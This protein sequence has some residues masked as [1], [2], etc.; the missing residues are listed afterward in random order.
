MKGLRPQILQITVRNKSISIQKEDKMA[1]KYY[2]KIIPVYFF[3]AFL[4]VAP[5]YIHAENFINNDNYS[6]GT[7]DVLDIIVWDN[8][9]MGR[10]VEVSSKGTFTFPLIGKVHAKGLSIFELEN[11]ITERLADGYINDPQVSISVK[12]YDSQKVFLFGEVARPGSYVLK[13]KTHI[14]ELISKAGGFTDKSGRI[15][16]IVRPSRKSD[17]ESDIIEMNLGMFPDGGVSNDFY[18][19]N[20]DSIYIDKEQRIFIIGNVLKKGEFKWEKGLTIRTAIS[21]AGGPK[22]SAALK[23][24]KIIRIVGG[25]EVKIDTRMDDLVK[26]DDI[27]EV[28]ERY[29]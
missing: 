11:Y 4:N 22:E 20:G 29:F 12:K 8:N 16:K 3:I 25:K 19:I 10:S 13:R 15:I 18:V 24:T 27:I 26:P 5:L 7:D 1:N 9:D 21:L 6:I 2:L 23:R 14:L 28:P 17:G